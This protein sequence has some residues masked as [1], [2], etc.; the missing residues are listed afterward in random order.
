MVFDMGMKLGFTPKA[1]NKDY[2]FSRQDHDEVIFS[3]P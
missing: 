2:E 3:G 1:K